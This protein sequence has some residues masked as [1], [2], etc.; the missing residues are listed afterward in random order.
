MYVYTCI[1]TH[2]ELLNKKYNRMRK[3]F[4][5]L[6][7]GKLKAVKTIKTKTSIVR[8]KEWSSKLKGKYNSF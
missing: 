1:Q 7:L 2:T 8:C 3:K 5:K 6:F 4:S